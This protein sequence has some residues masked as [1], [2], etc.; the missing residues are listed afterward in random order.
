MPGSWALWGLGLLF[1]SR[2]NPDF[3]AA[4]QQNAVLT[5]QAH[6][7]LVVALAGR[8]DQVNQH[9]VGELA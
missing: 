3:P 6:G 2:G 4:Q 8:L 5:K 9:G 1:E 7:R